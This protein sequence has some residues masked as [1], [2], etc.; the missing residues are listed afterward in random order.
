VV[1]AQDGMGWHAEDIGWQV[2]NV[3]CPMVDG[4]QVENVGWLVY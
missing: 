2:E 1:V 4:S 3:G